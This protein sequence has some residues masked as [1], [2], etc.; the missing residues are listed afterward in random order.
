MTRAAR[1]RNR[2]KPWVLLILVG[3]ALNVAVGWSLLLIPRVSQ[4]AD[5]RV[6]QYRNPNTG[7]QH[8][9][10]FSAIHQWFGVHEHQFYL[11]RRSR[12]RPVPKRTSVYW[13]WLPWDTDTDAIT[14]G[15]ALF[16]AFEPEHPDN[17]IISTTRVGFPALALE[18]DSLI[19]DAVILSN[20]SLSTETR[21][22]FLGRVDGAVGATKAS[23]WS[24]AQHTLFPYRPIW[25][26]FVINTLFYALVAVALAW[27]LRCIRHA[28]RMHRG[29][30]PTCAYEL[31]HDF[32]DGC[33]ECGWRRGGQT[34][35]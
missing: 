25:T 3:S 33:P 2:L 27:I 10:F 23:V 26:G 30:C 12:A 35:P 22:G 31:H 5:L 21:H 32:R 28:R 1:I 24:H 11:T 4:A 18:T 14:R 16:I 15:N 7:L 20:G 17:T 29:C 34:E 6:V 9:A 8:D 19:D 13:T